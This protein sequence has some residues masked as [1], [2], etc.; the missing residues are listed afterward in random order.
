MDT[1]DKLKYINAAIPKI[2]KGFEFLGIKE[3]KG[4]T[5]QTSFYLNT[6]KSQIQFYKDSYDSEAYTEYVG[7]QYFNADQ[8]KVDII[9]NDTEYL[10]LLIINQVGIKAK[11]LESFRTEMLQI[12]KLYK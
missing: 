1:F 5:G 3:E 2:I 11:D 6:E 9:F 4:P 7:E 8:K 12:H 10:L